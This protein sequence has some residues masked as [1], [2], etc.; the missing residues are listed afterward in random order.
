MANS[1]QSALAPRPAP[2][3]KAYLLWSLIAH[4][5]L[6]A[7]VLGL[8]A[9][10]AGPRLDLNQKPIQATLVRRG[11]ARDP[12][13]LPRIEEPPPPP[14]KVEAPPPPLPQPDAP[15]PPP[16]AP[17]LKPT[18]A[19]ASRAAPSKGA[20]DS[21]GRRSRLFDAFQK[22]SQR[23]KDEPLEGDPE[24]D[25]E[26]DSATGEG[27]RYYGL[28]NRD[29]KRYYDVSHTIPDRERVGLKADVL[30]KVSPAGAVEQV[31]LVTG[32][33][34][35]LFDNAVLAAVKKA[36]PFPAPPAHLRDTL[37]R[38]GVVLRFKP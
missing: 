21:A 32:S 7:G 6:L 22:T 34:N 15:P 18:Q 29:V 36:A 4:A 12:K 23:A 33:G 11:Q 20:D 17:G 25:P 16:K 13:L 3:L 37:H 9:W 31:K 28:I 10:N 8:S 5:V 2:E 1:V 14:P 26:G 24:G 35:E 19:P 30:I 27:E 38:E